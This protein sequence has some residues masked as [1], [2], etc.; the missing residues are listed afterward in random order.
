[1]GMV[2]PMDPSRVYDVVIVGAG[3]AGLAAA[4]YAATEGLHVVV[5]DCRAFGGQAGASARIEN[6]LGFPTG[7]SGQA[8]A[9]RAFVQAQKFGA[10]ILIPAQAVALDCSKAGPDGALLLK[11]SDEREL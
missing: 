10:E 2:K 9:G 6:Y 5:V 11:L 7:I 3:P 1:M 4:V 8:L